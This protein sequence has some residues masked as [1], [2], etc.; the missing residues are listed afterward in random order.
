MNACSDSQILSASVGLHLRCA[1]VN[2][3]QE[4]AEDGTTE[5]T[6]HGLFPSGTASMSALILTYASVGTITGNPRII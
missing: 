1:L 6:L 2:L 3:F 5:N 4:R